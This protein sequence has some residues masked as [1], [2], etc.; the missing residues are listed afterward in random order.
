MIYEFELLVNDLVSIKKTNEKIIARLNIENEKF[1]DIEN[2][3]SV[4]WHKKGLNDGQVITFQLINRILK[5][6][7][8]YLQ[9]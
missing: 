2:K 8:K 3:S 4:D 1:E 5:T 7:I 6:K 9:E